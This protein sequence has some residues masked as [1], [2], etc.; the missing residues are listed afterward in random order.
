MNCLHHFIEHSR[1][2][3]TYC[4]HCGEHRALLASPPAKVAKEPRL[5]RARRPQQ[6]TLPFGMPVAVGNG[7]SMFDA[8]TMPGQIDREFGVPVD[9]VAEAAIIAEMAKRGMGGRRVPEGDPPNTY[10]PGESE[11]IGRAAGVIGEERR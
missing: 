3:V 8:P 5:P 2:A 7:G 9:P 4:E 10:R 1:L 11:T 6:P